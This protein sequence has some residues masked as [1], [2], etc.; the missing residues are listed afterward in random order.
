MIYT[1]VEF[2][3]D[4]M[5][6]EK[7]NIQITDPHFPIRAFRYNSKRTDLSANY[8]IHSEIEMIY[9]ASGEM[10]FDINDEQIRV[11][12]GSVLF[13]K[14]NTIHACHV[15]S[16]EVETETCLLQFSPEIIFG[17]NLFTDY[18]YLTNFIS[19]NEAG[20]E[21]IDAYA[22]SSFE[23]FGEIMVEIIK[24]FLAKNIAYEITIKAY[25]YK[26]ISLLY[27]KNIL[28]P[29]NDM[30]SNKKIELLEKLEPVFRLVE[31]NY[32]NNL[33]VEMAAEEMFL[34]YHYFCRLFKEATG[35]TFKEYLNFVR[36]SIAEKLL[37]KSD[38]NLLELINQ[39]G[40]SSLA[41]FNRVFKEHKGINP[42]EFRKKFKV[43][44]K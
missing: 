1:Y 19:S 38:K 40:F 15:S 17:T 28:H 7:E 12:S 8:H 13:I 23:S 10:I 14:G 33:T 20:Y 41:Y 9:V 42:S 43:N 34:N 24:E 11:K 32:V 31:T 27:R 2:G 29:E 36:I 44:D 5:H 21:I 35:K 6:I 37:I 4:F 30:L 26:L 39:C 25:I 3:E 22:T 18:K 16:K